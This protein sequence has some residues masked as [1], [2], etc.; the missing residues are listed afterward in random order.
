M[1]NLGIISNIP[2]EATD[3]ETGFQ[4]GLNNAA[5]TYDVTQNIMYNQAKLANAVS[6]YDKVG[7]YDLIVTLGGLVVAEYA[8]KYVKNVPFISLFGG[9]LADFPGTLT[10]QFY[11]GVA[12]EA[13]DFNNERMR[14]LKGPKHKFDESLICLLI[15]PNSGCYNEEKA[16]WRFLGP[17]I[18]ASNN[19]EIKDAFSKID[20]NLEAM[21][22]SADPIFTANMDDLVDAANNTGLHMCYPFQEYSNSNGSKKPK[23]GKH[24]LHGPSLAEAHTR[25]GEMAAWI[26]NNNK[27]ASVAAVPGTVQDPT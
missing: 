14:Y 5:I 3:R 18:N 16:N 10:G 4:K 24:T 2:F 11:G 12:L 17:T 15:N 21:V 26:V 1:P 8:L 25:L 23:K 20:K 27:P 6:A 13:F 9:R 19:Q 7:I 22:V